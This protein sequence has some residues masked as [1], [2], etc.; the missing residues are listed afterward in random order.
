MNTQ[1]VIDEEWYRRTVDFNEEDPHG[2]YYSVP[3][4]DYDENRTLLTVTKAVF[5][6]HPKGNIR[7]PVAVAGYQITH[8]Y[9]R[10]EFINK[11]CMS[12]APGP[13]Q[14]CSTVSCASDLLE[15]YLLDSDAYIIASKNPEFTGQFFGQVEPAILESLVSVEIY[16]RVTIYDYQAVCFTV[17]E[18]H[19]SGCSILL[20]PFKYLFYMFTYLWTTAIWA[21]TNMHFASIVNGFLGLGQK[22]SATVQDY[23]FVYGGGPGQGPPPSLNYYDATYSVHDGSMEELSR[24][25]PDFR[26][27]YI[28]R[29]RPRPCDQKIELVKMNHTW[30]RT[31]K[32][33]GARLENCHTNGC[34]R[35]Y[36]V[37]K[38]PNSNMLFVLLER[39]CECVPVDPI[40][41]DPQEVE[42]NET[43]LC[44]RQNQSLVRKR[45]PDCRDYHPEE[46]E[47]I[48]HCKDSGVDALFPSLSLPLASAMVVSVVVHSFSHFL[49]SPFFTTTISSISSTP[50][51]VSLDQERS[52]KAAIGRL[53]TTDAAPCITSPQSTN[54]FLGVS[55]AL[56]RNRI[57]G[58]C[59]PQKLL[60][61]GA[62][63]PA[64]E[65][66]EVTGFRKRQVVAQTFPRSGASAPATVIFYFLSQSPDAEASSLGETSSFIWRVMLPDSG[67]D[68]S[69]NL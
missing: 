21:L 17:T 35:P 59:I 53:M 46:R 56:P 8:E 64:S 23:D 25:W 65:L 51:I 3:H 13:D 30:L 4:N 2:Y 1:S 61:S 44:M 38:I 9:I 47:E 58:M 54:A 55:S 60:R 5:L 49:Q 45:P 33:F 6:N 69:T 68:V 12:V 32:A 62:S 7:V 19:T 24:Y 57:A 20:T 15:C 26:D 40:T 67:L 48:S 66:F 16:N 27:A 28:N 29:T 41:V 37:T 11:T 34:D 42:Y 22:P 18:T 43:D 39:V 36:W 31:S 63:E 52:R 14:S 50:R 10:S